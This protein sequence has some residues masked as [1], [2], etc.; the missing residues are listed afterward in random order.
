[1]NLVRVEN[2]KKKLS[3]S[4]LSMAAIERKAGLKRNYIQ[5]IV[6]GRT[7]NVPLEHINAISS[8]LECSPAEIIDVDLIKE[9]LDLDKYHNVEWDRFFFLIVL[10]K[11]E[12][13]LI[14]QEIIPTFDDI[15]GMVRSCYI[16][17]FENNKK[18]LDDDFITWVIKNHFS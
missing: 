2:L 7:K 13:E 17:A 4:R 8:A 6:Y 12:N 18:E 1:M 5:N 3:E 15:I 9:N 10:N 16:Y 11:I 14:S